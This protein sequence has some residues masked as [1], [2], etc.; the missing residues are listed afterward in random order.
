AG[1]PLAQDTDHTY[2]GQEEDVV[3]AHA[4]VLGGCGVLV[5]FYARLDGGCVATADRQRSPGA[6][7]RRHRDHTIR[8][9]IGGGKPWP[10]VFWRYF[11][12]ISAPVAPVLSSHSFRSVSPMDSSCLS[13]SAGM[14]SMVRPFS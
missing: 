11:S 5:L 13:S 12:M 14:V 4:R 7:Y 9:A 3:F 6:P 2:A 8:S 10:H 1:K